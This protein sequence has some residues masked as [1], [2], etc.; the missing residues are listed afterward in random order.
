MTEA[1]LQSILAGITAPDEDTMTAAKKRQAELAKPPGSL[2]ML[3]DYAIRLAGITGQVCPQPKR[4][5]VIVA[6]ADH[7][8]AAAG[9][10]SAP[11]SVT[12]RQCINM[13]RRKTGMSALA[14]CFGDD[15]VVCDVGVKTELPPPVVNRKLRLGTENLLEAPAMTRQEAVDAIAVG[16]ELAQSAKRDGIDLVGIGEMGIGNTTPAT[17]L[18]SALTGEDPVCLTG[19]GGGLTAAAW[20][21]KKKVIAEVYRRR[22]PDGSDPLDVMSKVGGLELAAMTGM[23]LGCAAERLPAVVDGFLSIV[24]ALCA[25]RLCP[26]V[27][28]YLFLSHASQESAYEA[29]ANAL[30]LSPCLL[31]RMRLGEGSG[32]PL[33]FRIL[34]GACAVHKNMATFAEAEI[35]D[36]YLTPIRE[37]M[38]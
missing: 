4:C 27:K 33:M 6:A 1:K 15:V 2:G 34:Q 17:L 13:T 36:D 7:G 8:I 11:Q 20:E 14:A 24:A 38:E 10:S 3:E 28:E 30:G 35:N 25:V 18:L 22:Q 31:L 37:T 12:A 32:C 26:T 19:R 5:R 9:V 29:A 21:R 23:F 16:M